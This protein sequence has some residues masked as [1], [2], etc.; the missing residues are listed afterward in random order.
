MRNAMGDL[1]EDFGLG[2][3]ESF[4]PEPIEDETPRDKPHIMT[5]LGAIEPE[6]LGPT[7][8]HE[9]LLAHPPAVLETDPDLSIPDWDAALA[10]VE[11]FSFSGGSA[12]VDCSPPDNGR[13]LPGL[14]WVA[15]RVA[16]HII[17]VAGFHKDLHSRPYTHGKDPDELAEALVAELRQG[18]G[19]PPIFPGLLKAGS[20]LNEITEGERTAFQA[21]ARAHKVTGATITTH[22]EAG[23][24]ALEQIELLASEG[25]DPNR[26][27]LGHM[28]RRY[29]DEDYIVAALKT[30]AF[31]SFDQLGKP[32]HGPDEP[33][34]AMLARLIEAGYIGQLLI[35]QD[36]ARKSVRPAYG[37]APGWTY[38]LDRFTLMLME[39]GV[40]AAA[41]RQLL[42][43]NPVRA[44]TIHPPGA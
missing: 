8:I 23:T 32:N 7:L 19:Q 36:L 4:E 10:D 24:M 28:N 29:R 3:G 43:D 16:V 13:D 41:V 34:A 14:R 38:M 12:I 42:V 31:V 44:L 11:A 39:A 21:V 40:E 1:V 22:T 25:V 2:P 17:A 33:K 26:V 18:V 6:I 30:G 37:G 15:E 27:I 9:H 20:S 5:V 35:S